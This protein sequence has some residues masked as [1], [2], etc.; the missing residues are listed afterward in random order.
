MLLIIWY[1]FFKKRPTLGLYSKTFRNYNHVVTSIDK[2]VF[3]FQW[4]YTPKGATYPGG[5]NH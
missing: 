4:I 5:Y 3:C 1:V 2:Q